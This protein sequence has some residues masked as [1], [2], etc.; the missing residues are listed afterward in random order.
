M[1]LAIICYNHFDATISLAKYLNTYDENIQIDLIFLFSQTYLSVEIID[2]SN[3]DLED[4]FVKKE[5]LHRVIDKEI[6]DYLAP[7]I[8]LK[9][10]IFKK[11]NLFNPTNLRLLHELSSAIKE[12][13]YDL[14]HFVG[15][16]HWII[17]L[18]YYIRGV[19]KV[20]TLH[21][22]YP[23]IPIPKYRLFRHKSKINL[24][25][26]TGSHIIIPSNTSCDRFVK[27][28]TI[29][30][31]NLSVIPFGPFEIYRKY[32]LE[33][34][35]KSDQLLLYYGNISRYKGVD[36]LIEAMTKVLESN[37]ELQL[38]IAGGGELPSDIT[39]V[40]PNI[41]IIN[42]YLNNREIAELNQKATVVVCPYR[43][44]S[45]SGVVMTSFAFGNPIIATNVGALP[46]VIDHGI[47]GVI[48]EA[49]DA[50]IL[51]QAIIDLFRDASTLETL[52]NNIM[53]KYNDSEKSWKNITLQTYQLYEQLIKKPSKILQAS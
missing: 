32:A 36:I 15:N 24:L 2:L 28:F 20:H 38:I 29:S 25:I 43:S 53:F 17:L 1:K 13:H 46:E 7:N 47:T 34:L 5:M 27:N 30:S 26:R 45:Q 16:N 3:K 33:G 23:F 37:A 11:L 31:K 12:Q 6:F 4:G 19:K 35:K 52:R 49:G 14:L 21:E 40:H 9:V 44:A 42:K 8:N 10:F 22:P 18:N 51:S 39:S 50:A 41:K 48:I